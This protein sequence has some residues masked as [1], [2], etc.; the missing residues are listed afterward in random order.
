VCATEEMPQKLKI[1]A[2]LQYSHEI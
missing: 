1:A 2:A